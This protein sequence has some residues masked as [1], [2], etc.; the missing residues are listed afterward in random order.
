MIFRRSKRTLC[1]ERSG[2]RETVRYPEARAEDGRRI[3]AQPQR[4]NS[5]QENPS[6][7]WSHNLSLPARPQVY[8]RALGGTK[9]SPSQLRI[10][11]LQKQPKGWTCH[12]LVLSPGFA[13]GVYAFL[14]LNRWPCPLWIYHLGACF[15][16]RVVPGFVTALC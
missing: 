2:D 7:S 8:I 3:V 14:W 12:M 9:A 4:H 1:F 16:N 6:R 10:C 11:N 13:C 5:K 15:T